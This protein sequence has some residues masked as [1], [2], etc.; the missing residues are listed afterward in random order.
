MGRKT[1]ALR[2]KYQETVKDLKE[3]AKAKTKA[4][5]ALQDI[6]NGYTTLSK[7]PDKLKEP[8]RAKLQSD[9]PTV[10]DEVHKASVAHE[11]AKQKCF[12]AS[13]ALDDYVKTKLDKK[14]KKAAELQKKLADL[15]ELT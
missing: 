7:S 10:M 9:L 1:E 12:A 13:K 6:K 11:K 3:T 5:A 2:K 15:P 4:L 14:D 8:Q